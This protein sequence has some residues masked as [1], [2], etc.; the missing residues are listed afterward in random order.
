MPFDFE[1]PDDTEV[2]AATK[3]VEAIGLEQQAEVK[4][5]TDRYICLASTELDY[6]F[7]Q[8]PV[9]FDL[10]G[11]SAGMFRSD[12]RG[13][14]IRYNPWIFGKYYR[15]NFASTVPHEV[16]HY[17]VHS[18]FGRRRGIKPHGSEW[19]A[20]MQ[21]FKADPAVTFKLDLTGVPQ[22]RQRTHPYHCGCRE[23]ELS[24]TRHK[25]ILSG[26][27]RYHCCYC[28]GELFYRKAGQ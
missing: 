17:V 1:I 9:L 15:Q 25:R 5:E 19:L 13:S 10:G 27:G 20:V 28:G 16:A 12:K 26:R 4:A 14:C 24:M 23:H 11:R 8:I 6:S 3:K 21:L 18:L 7:A 2:K 22:R